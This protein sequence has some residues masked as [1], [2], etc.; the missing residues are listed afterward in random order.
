M[1]LNLQTPKKQAGFI[2][3]VVGGVMAAGSLLAGR[4]AAKAQKAARRA[5]QQI[6]R[7]KN[8]QNKREFL[9]AANQAQAEAFLAPIQAG[10]DV[11]SS[12][13]Q[14]TSGSIRRQAETS[15]QEFQKMGELGEAA[16]ASLNRAARASFASDVFGAVGSFSMSSGGGTLINKAFGI[17]E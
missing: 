13:A 16:S 15:S 9:A 11:S 1:N 2:N 7:I 3:L 8:F 17:E 6:N 10:A 12:F 4:K 14:A 5:Q